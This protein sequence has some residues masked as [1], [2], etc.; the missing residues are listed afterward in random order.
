MLLTIYSYSNI[1]TDESRLSFNGNEMYVSLYL[2]LDDNQANKKIFQEIAKKQ[3]QH[4][5]F[6][7]RLWI[8]KIVRY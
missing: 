5:I 4:N 3:D 6:I 8:S 1:D 2:E 7:I